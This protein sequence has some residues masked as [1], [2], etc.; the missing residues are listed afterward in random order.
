MKKC[1]TILTMT[2]LSSFV[3][4]GSSKGEVQRNIKR[5]G[6]DVVWG[7]TI[8]EKE[9]IKFGLSAYSGNPWVYFSNYLDRNIDHFARNL[10][11]VGKRALKDLIIR[12]FKSRGAKMRIGRIEVKAGIATYRRWKRVVYD[13][14]RTR[15]V[16][17][18]INKR[19][20]WWTWT[21][22]VYTARVT[23]RIPLPNHHQPYVAFR[24]R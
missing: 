4:A 6:W 1:L 13:E 20:G 23:K 14:P 22:Q 2:V 24:I 5:G 3:F 12:S 7:V 10:R 18:W 11:G 19:W 15:K 21:V 16:K 9:Y 8:D 17:R